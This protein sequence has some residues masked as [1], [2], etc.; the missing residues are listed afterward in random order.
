VKPLKDK[1]AIIVIR[2][3]DESSLEKREILEKEILEWLKDNQGFIPWVKHVETIKIENPE[4][5]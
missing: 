4:T 2:L 3:L 1:R 5:R